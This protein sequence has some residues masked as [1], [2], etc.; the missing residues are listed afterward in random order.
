M[1]K[2]INLMPAEVTRTKSAIFQFQN[3]DAPDHVGTTDALSRSPYTAGEHWYIHQHTINAV[4][5]RLS[6]KPSGSPLSLYSSKELC[7][8]GQ[9]QSH[10]GDKETSE[11]KRD[12]SSVM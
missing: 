7:G 1:L 5:T 3:K 11:G 2:H 10:L 6:Y 8:S 9:C 12:M 4:I